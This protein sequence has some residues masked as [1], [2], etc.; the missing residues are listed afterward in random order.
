MVAQLVDNGQSN[1][2]LHLLNAGA[3]LENGLA[4]DRHPVRQRQV[5]AGAALAERRSLV[6]AKQRLVGPQAQGAELGRGGPIGDQDRHVVQPPPEGGWQLGQRLAHHPREAARRQAAAVGAER[7]ARRHAR[8]MLSSMDSTTIRPI[9]VYNHCVRLTGSPPRTCW[10]LN[11]STH[12]YW[13]AAGRG[14]PV[15]YNALGVPRL[16]AAV[17]RGA[18]SLLRPIDETDLPLLWKWENDSELTYFL[19]A[20]RH[21]TM[22]MDEVNR[23]YRQIRSDPTMELFIIE[24]FDG[25]RIG[26]VG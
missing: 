19:N 11:F 16:E 17:L 7:A 15:S 3:G 9:T 5:V 4:K 8:R 18:K 2:V 24:T 22:S 10:R 20:D 12:A 26:M 1:L 23:R 6:Q 14:R 25:E 21:R 13:P